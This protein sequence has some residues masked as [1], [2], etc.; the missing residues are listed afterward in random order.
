MQK[1]L[2][3]YLK[4]QLREQS[5][6]KLSEE[7]VESVSP[8]LYKVTGAGHSVCVWGGGGGGSV[9]VK[10]QSSMV[11]GA[12]ERGEGGRREL[13][14]LTAWC[15]KLS[16]SLLVLAWRWQQIEEAMWRVGGI[17]CNAEVMPTVIFIVGTP[18]LWETKFKKE[19]QKIILYENMIFK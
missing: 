4:W 15:W 1:S 14:F 11:H 3:V 5:L 13:S 18:Q 16:F 9:S 8:M 12:K 17:T 7:V 2:S 6:F 10:G 19:I